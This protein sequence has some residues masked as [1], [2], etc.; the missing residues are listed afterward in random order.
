MAHYHRLARSHFDD[1]DVFINLSIKLPPEEEDEEPG[2]MLLWKFALWFFVIA[3]A[4]TILAWLYYVMQPKANLGSKPIN[5]ETTTLTS[6]ESEHV[7]KASNLPEL[8]PEPTTTQQP[9][10]TIQESTTVPP[11]VPSTEIVSNDDTVNDT[12]NP[13]AIVSVEHNDSVVEIQEV[14][15]HEALLLAERLKATEIVFEREGIQKE[16][17]HSFVLQRQLSEIQEQSRRDYESQKLFLECQ[18]RQREEQLSERRHQEAIAAQ[19]DDPNWLDK[20]LKGTFQK[21]GFLIENL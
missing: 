3:T 19:M 9:E 5:H 15:Q 4:C 2:S 8:Y 20:L 17:A 11:P 7:V 16:L 18:L 6:K 13:S 10:A 14:A 1:D 21:G 12:N